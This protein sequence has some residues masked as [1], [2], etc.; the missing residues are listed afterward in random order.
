[1]TGRCAEARF[2]PDRLKAGSSLDELVTADALFAIA[3]HKLGIEGRQLLNAGQIITD[4]ILA[5]VKSKVRALQKQLVQQGRVRGKR[6]DDLLGRIPRSPIA[7]AVI[8]VATEY[9]HP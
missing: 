2:T 9:A 5:A 4:A 3:S 1:M 7:D 8:M 6:L